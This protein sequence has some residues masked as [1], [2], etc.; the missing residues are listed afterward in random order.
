MRRIR[1][2]VSFGTGFS[3][4]R[5]L[6]WRHDGLII[7]PTANPRLPT[8]RRSTYAQ[9]WIGHEFIGGIP[10]HLLWF[11]IY[12]NDNTSFLDLW[13]DLRNESFL[14]GKL[15]YA[16]RSSSHIMERRSFHRYYIQMVTVG[17]TGE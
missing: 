8:V 15:I 1:L 2:E 16:V 10:Y 11:T 13:G 3:R 7:F 14:I 17:A 5:T 4:T 12:R 6:T 9:T